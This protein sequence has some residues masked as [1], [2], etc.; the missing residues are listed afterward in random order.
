MGV[1]RSVYFRDPW[2]FSSVVVGVVIFTVAIV[3]FLRITGL[4]EEPLENNGGSF[5]PWNKNK[6]LE[7]SYDSVSSFASHVFL[8]RS[9]VW[10]CCATLLFS[11]DVGACFVYCPGFAALSNGGVSAAAFLLFFWFC[12]YFLL[13]A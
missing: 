1:L 10:F 5:T 13:Y 11:T 3:N 9:V 8:Y 7:H 2:R 6:I 4:K 12:F